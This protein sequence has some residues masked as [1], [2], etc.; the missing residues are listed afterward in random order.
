MGDSIRHHRGGDQTP[1]GPLVF[2]VPTSLQE[3]VSRS[4]FQVALTM[5]RGCLNSC[6][7]CGSTPSLVAQPHQL[8]AGKDS[9]GVRIFMA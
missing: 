2:S 9:A 4:V 5:F 6:M 1:D 3:Y 8:C 7:F